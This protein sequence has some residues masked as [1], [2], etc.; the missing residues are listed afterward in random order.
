MELTWRNRL[1]QEPE[2]WDFKRW[3]F[4]DSQSLSPAARR[5]YH[6]NTRI[7]ANVLDGRPLNEV[8]RELRLSPSWVTQLM[9]RCLAGNEDAPPA[10]TQGLV[11]HRRLRRSQRKT[12]LSTL[13]HSA[14]DRCAFEYVM[15]TVPGLKAHLMKQIRRAVTRHRRGQNL[16]PRRFHA[17]FVAYLIAQDWPQDVYPFT[18][19]SRGYEAARRFLKD[20]LADLKMPRDKPRVTGPKIPPVC[21]F[22]EIHIDEAHID[23]KGAA[24]VVLHNQMKPVRLA[25]ISLLLAR[26]VGTGAYLAGS[27]AL[28]TH[29][30][31]ADI[32]GLLEQLVQPWEPLTLTAPGLSYS[33]KAGFPSALNESFCRPT[34]GI[35]RLDNALVHLSHQVRRMVCDHLGATANFGLPKNPKARA[36]IEQAF[37]RLNVDIHRLPSTT[38]S[39][40][41]DVLR[42]PAKLQKEPPFV[43]LKAL[44]EAI[45]VLLTEYNHSPLGN[46]G[47]QTPMEQMQYQMANHLLPLRATSLGPGLGPYERSQVV[48]VRKGF[49]IDEPRINFEGC[50]YTGA[51]LND[52]SRINQKVTI[53]FD[54]R[55][56]RSL[57]VFTL[58]GQ[59]L[60]EVLAPGTWQRFAH[61]ISMRKKINRLVR[62]NALSRH[63]PLG[64]FFDYMAAHYTL[65]RDA[66]TLLRLTAGSTPEDE[67]QEELSVQNERTASDDKALKKAL[68]QLPDWTPAM[69][70]K[71]R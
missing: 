10:L 20:S 45:G 18:S 47:A 54:I 55:D 27:F 63:D 50:Q 5:R 29:P 49:T 33:A 30:D 61:S 3:P 9:N 62:E 41:T 68:N 37:R 15:N 59:R 42:E 24:A 36:L 57:Q 56:I 67:Q 34:F 65:P 35:V 58:D 43:S 51:A 16:T 25:R 17:M 64:G 26:D 53:V 71:R 2:W 19:P 48:T 69:A 4:V 22:Q 21:A 66:L 13:T 14:G 28:T 6:T 40:P 70:K 7:V 60:G 11:P 31:S 38:G 39:H 8:A 1:M 32:L 46:Q 44:E 23:C 12:A 52:A